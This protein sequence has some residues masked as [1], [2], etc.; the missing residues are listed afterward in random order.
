MDT[1]GI[2]D[3]VSNIGEMKLK[4]INTH[5]KKYDYFFYFDDYEDLLLK[6]PEYDNFAV[7]LEI[8][9]PAD[10]SLEDFYDM[11]EYFK[12]EGYYKDNDKF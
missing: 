10:F 9:V 7:P 11:I 1:I 3:Y 8:S 2:Y 4:M 12:E 5:F 6:T